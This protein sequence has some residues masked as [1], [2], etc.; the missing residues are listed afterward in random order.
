[1]ASDYGMNFGFRRSDESVAVR[2]GRLKTPATGTFLLGTLV[3]F[4]P[5]N[6][7]LLMQAASGQVGEGATVGL[8]VQEEIWNRS[9][10][11]TMHLDSY[12]LG[13]A[14]NG[15]PSVIVAGAGTKVWLA[16]TAEI[17]QVDGR[18]IPAVTLVDWGTPPTPLT[19]LTWNGT[20]Y[21][22]ATATAANSM[23][24]VTWVDP[25]TQTLE[26]VLTR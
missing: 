12:M 21:T 4:D 15:R 13:L 25:V 3:A 24:K 22:T 6:V 23:L 26:A 7:G 10:Y 9:I 18:V 5:A 19:Y 2:E 14:Y 16:N 11:E 1:M 17:T 20:E 8:L